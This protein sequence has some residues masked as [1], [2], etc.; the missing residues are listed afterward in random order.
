[1][2]QYLLIDHL[3]IN[4]VIGDDDCGSLPEVETEYPIVLFVVPLDDLVEVGPEERRAPHHRKSGQSR[5]EIGRP[6]EESLPEQGE[7]HD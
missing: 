1:M 3:F 7:G 4:V 6:P 2:G 5:R